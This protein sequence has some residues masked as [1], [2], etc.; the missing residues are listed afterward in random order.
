MKNLILSFLFFTILL[1]AYAEGGKGSAN[2]NS[3][4]NNNNGATDTV[5]TTLGSDLAHKLWDVN[6]SLTFIPAYDIYCKWDTSVIHHHSSDAALTD[7]ITIVLEGERSCYVHPYMGSVTSNFG[8]RR[9]RMHYGVDINLETGDSVVAAFDGK[10]RISKL[11]KSYGNLVIVRHANG[12][13]TYYAHL[14]KLLVSPEQDV[15]A[16]EVIG[17]GGNTGHSYGSHLHFEVRYKGRPIDPNEMIDFSDKRLLA[18]TFNI[19]KKNLDD[20][21]VVKSSSSKSKYQKVPYAKN[22]KPGTKAP[23]KNKYYTVRKGDTLYSIAKRYNTTPKNIAQKNGMS[24]KATL[25]VG[26]K[27]KI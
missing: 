25:A 11:N 15:K 2:K 9:S 21:S 8:Y 4:N 23:A 14:S 26:K 19:T 27:L 12:L 7:T 5:K 3:S 10:V 16:G 6:D 18:D 22:Y 1:T 17:L 13:E 20:L 24:T